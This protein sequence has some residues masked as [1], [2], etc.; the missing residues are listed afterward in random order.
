[1]NENLWETVLPERHKE[2]NAATWITLD[3]FKAFM[4]LGMKMWFLLNE[5][6]CGR[7]KCNFFC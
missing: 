1:M 2:A 5:I 4:M 7:S 3:T 6:F